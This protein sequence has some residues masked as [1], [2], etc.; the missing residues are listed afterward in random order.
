[1]IE[2]QHDEIAEYR[3]SIKGEREDRIDIHNIAMGL[4]KEQN[5]QIMND[6]AKSGNEKDL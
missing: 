1:M 3:C 4:V 6:K 2:N 5:K